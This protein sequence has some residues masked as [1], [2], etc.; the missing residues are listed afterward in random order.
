V[1]FL[2]KRRAAVLLNRAKG[3]TMTWNTGELVVAPQKSAEQLLIERNMK[4]QSWFDTS[5]ALTEAVTA[6]R[7]ARAVVVDV[8]FPNIRKGTQR[9]DIGHGWNIKLVYG[10]T[11]SLGD[12]ELTDDSGAKVPI[13]NQ[14]EAVIAK[15]AGTSAEGQY[16]AERLFKRQYSFSLAEYEKVNDMNI[17]ALVDDI[18]EVKPA[19]PQ[20]SAEPPKEV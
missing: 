9:V 4:I 10:F 8:L 15:I 19:S 17:R 20:L 1:W 7:A 3:Y 11:A 16:V 6:E 14:V 12:K 18:L 5:K 13:V 2:A